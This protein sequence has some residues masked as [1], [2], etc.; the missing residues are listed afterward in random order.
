MNNTHTFSFLYKIKLAGILLLLLSFSNSN[1]AQNVING[2]IYDSNTKLPLVGANIYLENTSIGTLSDENGN[3]LI[4]TKSNKNKF[5]LIASYIGYFSEEKDIELNKNYISIELYLKPSLL[6]LDQIVVTGT[7]T[8]RF[9]KDTPVSTRVINKEQIQNSGAS[10]IKQALSEIN[11]IVIHENQFG[12]GVNTVEIQGFGSQ[13]VQ[14]LVDGIKMIGRV[15]GELDI[16]TIP[17]NQVEKIELVKGAASALYGS[18]AMGGVINIITN[19]MNNDFSMTSDLSTGS[20][21]RL[22]GSINLNVP[23]NNWRPSLNFSYRKYDGYDLNKLTPSDDGTAYKKYHGQFNLNGNLNENT[24][25]NLR[26]LFFNENQNSQSSIIFRDRIENIQFAGR[27]E[28]TSKQII[29]SFNMKTGIEYSVFDHTYDQKVIS[30]GFIKNGDATLEK[31]LRGDVLF[32]FALGKNLINGG[33]SFEYEIIGSDRVINENQNSNLNNIFLQDEIVIND[34]STFLGGIRLDA[35]SVYGSQLTPK[36]AVMFK[37][38]INSR[39]R[40]SYSEGFRAPSFKE[41]YIEYVNL[42]V[43]Y[44]ITGNPELR[45]E[46]STSLQTDIEYWNDNNY[47]LKI[48]FNYNQISNLIDYKYLGIEDNYGIYKTANLEK[49]NTWGGDFDVEYFPY[50]FLNFK[51]GYGYFDSKDLQTNDQLLLKSKHKINFSFNLNF[52]GYL[53]FSFRGQF[54]GKQIWKDYEEIIYTGR[55][56]VISSYW[57]FHTNLNYKISEKLNTYLGMRNLNNYINKTWGPMPGREWYI[58]LKYEYK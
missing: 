32:D 45:P 52:I 34:W 57:L 28:L 1:N 30:S 15:N 9:L 38:S 33:Y 3:F 53:S 35:H 31:L 51:F 13:H 54:F 55:N 17:I 26:T 6:N 5:K 22:D 27:L 10:D 47:H 40:V 4:S 25:L 20:Y 44:H 39:I 41:L 18:E 2:K 12:T 23:V 8:E 14:I 29:N 21:G 50:D 24:E 46:K 56:E 42:N 43:G 36:A 37:P 49:V 11:G 7:R 19:K 58:G 16:S 48:H